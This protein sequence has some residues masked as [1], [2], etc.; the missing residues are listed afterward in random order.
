MKLFDTS[1]FQLQSRLQKIKRKEEAVLKSILYLMGYFT[2]DILCI[3]LKEGEFQN[4]YYLIFIDKSTSPERAPM[5]ESDL[6]K[7]PKRA[8]QMTEVIRSVN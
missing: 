4:Q 2:S 6:K 5:I 3:F 7:N 1:F 8:L